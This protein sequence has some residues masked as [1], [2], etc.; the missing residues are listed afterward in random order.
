VKFLIKKNK[1]GHSW[2]GYHQQEG[3]PNLATC[4]R[5]KQKSF[6]ILLY[7]GDMLEPICLNMM[8][9]NLFFSSSC[10]NYELFSPP[11]KALYLVQKLFLFFLAFFF[12]FSVLLLGC[13][14]S[15]KNKK[16]RLQ[17]FLFKFLL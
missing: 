5:G 7:F 17:D 6:G 4:K 9:S 3:L 1:L 15:P 8:T 12:L 10:G 13:G 14:N 11:K 16:N 2:V